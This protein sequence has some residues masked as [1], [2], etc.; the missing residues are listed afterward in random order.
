MSITADNVMQNKEITKKIDLQ[1]QK[2]AFSSGF[3][4]SFKLLSRGIFC[5]MQ[6]KDSKREKNTSSAVT[7]CGAA[8]H[9]KV[10][11][12]RT[13]RIGHSNEA[14]TKSRTE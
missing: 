9:Q 13:F 14:A 6:I 8:E 1:Q 4:P 7:S 11:Y 12:T 3:G 5:Q 10:H 2:R